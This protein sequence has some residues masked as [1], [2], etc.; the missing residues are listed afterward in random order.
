MEGGTS[1]DKRRPLSAGR[2]CWRSCSEV[3]LLLLPFATNLQNMDSIT[4]TC[5]ALSADVSL[6]C[7]CVWQSKGSGDLQRR[8]RPVGS[9]LAKGA[10]RHRTSLEFKQR[11]QV[12]LLLRRLGAYSSAR[13]HLM[14]HVDV[15]A[16]RANESV[17]LSPSQVS[18]MHRH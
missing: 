17:S 4:H 15:S 2:G 1:G 6:E 7:V 8:R 9:I 5:L 11:S 10:C 14:L 18:K 16:R 13:P 3:A 12:Q